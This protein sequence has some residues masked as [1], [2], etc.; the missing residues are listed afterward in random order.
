MPEYA[1]DANVVALATAFGEDMGDAQALLTG[2]QAALAERPVVHV[3]ATYA[4]ALSY[5]IANP[6]HLVFSEEDAP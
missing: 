5:S 6:T 4:A 1:L 2:L 3:E